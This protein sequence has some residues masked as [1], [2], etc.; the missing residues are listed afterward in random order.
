MLTVPVQ[1]AI[2]LVERKNSML[3]NIM[4]HS[5]GVTL[6]YGPVGA[7]YDKGSCVLIYETRRIEL[8]NATYGE[9]FKEFMH[10]VGEL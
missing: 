10:L 1:F 2:R 7:D 5:G 8:I 3:G 9:F 6:S 4:L